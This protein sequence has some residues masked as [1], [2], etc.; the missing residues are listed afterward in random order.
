MSTSLLFQSFGIR[1][2]K[3]NRTE[4]INGKTVFHAKVKERLI[5]CPCCISMKVIKFGH[6]NRKIRIKD[7]H[8]EYLSKKYRRRSWKKIKY[9][10]IDEFSFKKGRKHITIAVNL[11][12]GEIICAS[13]GKFK[14]SIKQQLLNRI[15]SNS[16]ITSNTRSYPQI[17]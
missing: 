13:E 9:S 7:H 10:C 12:T 17:I 2:V 5:R 8:K 11:Q 16:R 15:I 4:Y 3:V 6:K 1:H 14:E